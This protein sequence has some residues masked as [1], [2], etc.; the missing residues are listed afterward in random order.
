MA[1]KVAGC[2]EQA[3]ICNTQ[4]AESN[5]ST[6]VSPRQA[7]GNPVKG[8]QPYLLR[9]FPTLAPILTADK[10]RVPRRQGGGETQERKAGGG[11]ECRN[12]KRAGDNYG[13]G[14]EIIIEKK[15]IMA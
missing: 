6:R 4:N 15:A 7:P 10:S 9:L 2:A 11:L 14:T 1:K 12:F 5:R 3:L 8:P 13:G